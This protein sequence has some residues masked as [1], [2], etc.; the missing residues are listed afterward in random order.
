MK[1]EDFRSELNAQIGRARKQGRPHIEING[2]ELHRVVGG[3]PGPAHGMPMCCE[4][5]RAE[6]RRGNAEIVYET[7]S[8]QGAA[9][10]IR[11][12]FPR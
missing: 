9:L 7:H 2:G 6:L 10:T 3:Y 5:M 8:G 4:A 1:A 12:K 11:Y